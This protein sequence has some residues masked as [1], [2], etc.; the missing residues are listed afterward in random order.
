MATKHENLVTAVC[1]GGAPKR[2]SANDAFDSIVAE[3]LSFPAKGFRSA[4]IRRT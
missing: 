4:T 3:V 1:V 2:M